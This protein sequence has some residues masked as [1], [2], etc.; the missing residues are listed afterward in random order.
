MNEG[1]A[2]GSASLNERPIIF[3]LKRRTE[4]LR[5]RKGWVERRKS[6]LIEARP[7][8]KGGHIGEGYTATKR[9]GSAVVRNRAKRRLRAAASNLLPTLGSEGV[10]Y[11]FVAR[12]DT[13]NIEWS[14]L[15]ND[16]KSA[17]SSLS[18]K[19]QRLRN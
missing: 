8:L 19:L 7:R 13:A 12:M 9:I 11:V 17:L 18:V 4:F 3:R 15:F 10:D 16:M 5:V 2:D 14:R 6:L 1:P